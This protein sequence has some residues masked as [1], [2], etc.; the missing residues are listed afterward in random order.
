MTTVIVQDE[1]NIIVEVA[2]QPSV[3]VNIDRGVEGPQGPQGIQGPPGP[4]GPAG[5]DGPPNIL[6][7][8]T[9][10]ST[11]VASATI[12]GTSPNQILNLDL[13]KGDPGD[14]NPEMYVILADAEL[15]RDESI[16]A[17]FD[18]TTQANLAAQY[19]GQLAGALN[20]DGGFANSTYGGISPINCGGA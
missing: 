19:A 14:V 1:N 15:A 17:A 3:I 18:A 13:P 2:P 5:Q 8:G 12:T 4:Q 6:T 9:V 11:E 10:I 20:I 16:S 7:I